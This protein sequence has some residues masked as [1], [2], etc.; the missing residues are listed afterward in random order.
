MAKEVAVLQDFRDRI[1]LQ[2]A[3]GEILVKLYYKISPPIAEF[4]A[5]RDTLRMMVRWSLIPVVGVSSIAVK[6]GPM[7]T[8]LIFGLVILTGGCASR[9]YAHRK[10]QKGRREK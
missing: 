8:I 4:I 5:E 1:L 9:V 6:A 3:W 10:R 7:A 2:T